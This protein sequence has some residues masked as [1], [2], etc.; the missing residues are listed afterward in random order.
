MNPISKSFSRIPPLLAICWVLSS[1]QTAP[2]DRE[3]LRV[4]S[5]PN[6][7]HLQ[8]V[9]ALQELAELKT[10]NEPSAFWT[11][12]ANNPKFRT[13][14]RRR[15]ILQ[16]FYRHF[17]PGMTFADVGRML[18][19]ATWIQ[20][21]NAWFEVAVEGPPLGS[22]P[23]EQWAVLSVLPYEVSSAMDSNGRHI[24]K[25][26]FILFSYLGDRAT[27]PELANCLR[28]AAPKSKIAG[29]I[30]LRI[31]SLENWTNHVDGEVWDEYGTLDLIP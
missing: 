23:G 29:D 4:I 12:I 28:G 19:H 11:A 21:T 9:H 14:H 26:T 2:P 27:V 17:K 16:L 22:K 8:F 10:V 13:D 7:T 1:C 18:D 25:G 6:T 5:D 15:A 3:M 31:E 24:A 20:N 30:I